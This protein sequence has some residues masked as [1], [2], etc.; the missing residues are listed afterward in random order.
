MY[1]LTRYP[2]LAVAVLPKV[3]PNHHS[4]RHATD[5][6]RRS[7][8]QCPGA[9]AV[10]WGSATRLLAGV[11]P[12]ASREFLL[13]CPRHLPTEHPQLGLVGAFYKTIEIE[14]GAWSSVLLLFNSTTTLYYENVLINKHLLLKSMG[15]CFAMGEG[16]CLRW[17]WKI[18][19]LYLMEHSI[20]PGLGSVRLPEGSLTWWAWGSREKGRHAYSEYPFTDEP[21]GC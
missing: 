16:G 12:E 9:T 6:G 11:C 1:I 15:W 13:L 4:G 14:A 19:N 3:K 5:A 2:L 17:P 8:G 21:T 18:L 20:H 10:R 7:A